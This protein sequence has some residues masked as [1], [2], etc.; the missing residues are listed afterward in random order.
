MEELSIR[1]DDSQFRRHLTNLEVAQLPFAAANAL[2]DTAKDALE[3]IQRRMEVVFDRPTRFTKNALMVWRA[4]KRNLEAQVKER[5]SVGRRHYLKVEEG[6]GARP[7]TGVEKLLS[8]RVAWGGVIRSVLPGEHARLDGSGN[9]SSGERNQVLSAL[10][11][12]R[13]PR[14]NTTERSA[15]RAPKRA[16]YFVPQHGLAPGVYRRA[17]PDDIAVRV[18]KFSD[19]APKYTPR[20]GFYEGVDEVWQ[21][22]LPDHLDR[23]LAEAVARAR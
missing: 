21:R 20:L 22:R 18:L 16:K 4:D 8:S 6:G 1:V 7:Q 5:P 14:T 23:R 17:K 11:A 2:N 3:Y 9:W 12:Q 19:K 10:G 15:K 13:D